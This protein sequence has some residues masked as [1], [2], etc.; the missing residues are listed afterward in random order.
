MPIY[1]YTC[2]ECGENQKHL[3]KA[4]ERDGPLDC[5]ECGLTALDREVAKDTPRHNILRAAN[6]DRFAA[7]KERLR[8]EEIMYD[9]PP[10]A[11]ETHQKHI[12]KL[13][14]AEANSATP[15]DQEDRHASNSG[16]DITK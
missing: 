12:A 13:Q 6:P 3:V 2:R 16:L 10:D 1:K 14:E 11:R 7:T 9:L 5:K 15:T 8:A 4:S